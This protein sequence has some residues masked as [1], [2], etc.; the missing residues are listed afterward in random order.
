ML[1]LMP[2][3]LM[4]MSLLVAAPALASESVRIENDHYLVSVDAADGRF[5]IVSRPSGKLF[6][7]DGI[8][9]GKGG[10][11]RVIDQADKVFGNGKAIEI[12][13]PDGNREQV[14]LYPGMPFVLFR[15]RCHNGAVR[16]RSS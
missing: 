4:V 15:R 6:L 3:T 5:T 10:A 11:V 14:A 8:L 13:Y 16:S 12:A 7:T 1:N 9:S 2:N